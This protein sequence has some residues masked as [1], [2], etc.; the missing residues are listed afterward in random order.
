MTSAADG[1]ANGSVTDRFE[2]LLPPSLEVERHGADGEVA[3]LRLTRAAKRNALERPD[4]ARH[5]GVLQR[6][7]RRG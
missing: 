2:P 3:V 7:A 6:A 5:R 4:R 1:H